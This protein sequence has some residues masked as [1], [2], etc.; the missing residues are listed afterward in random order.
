MCVGRPIG[1]ECVLAAVSQVGGARCLWLL[2]R[3][4]P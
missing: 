3:P 2:P 1:L 4:Q